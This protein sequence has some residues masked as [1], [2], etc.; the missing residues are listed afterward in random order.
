MHRSPLYLLQISIGDHTKDGHDRW[1]R[2]T[3]DDNRIDTE[4]L[5]VGTRLRNTTA[6][7]DAIVNSEVNRYTQ[8]DDSNGQNHSTSD[9]S[10]AE[11]SDPR[12]TAAHGR[13]VDACRHF[14][15]AV[16]HEQCVEEVTTDFAPRQHDVLRID[17]IG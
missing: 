9:A 1:R 8:P 2:P 5:R 7:F 17:V 11:L 16:E 14:E 10:L 13:P 4:E 3:R 6:G 15:P 12:L